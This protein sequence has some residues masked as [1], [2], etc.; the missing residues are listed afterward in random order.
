MMYN[1][2][3]EI[4]EIQRPSDKEVNGINIPMYV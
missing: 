2:I 4:V 3:G 1:S